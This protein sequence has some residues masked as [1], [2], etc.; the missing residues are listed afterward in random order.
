[1]CRNN[2]YDGRDMVSASRLISKR[3]SKALHFRKRA[4]SE[5]FEASKRW[6]SVKIRFGF[7]G[8]LRITWNKIRDKNHY[9]NSLLICCCLTRSYA[10]AWYRS[11]ESEATSTERRQI[12]PKFESLSTSP[13]HLCQTPDPFI[14]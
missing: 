5:G 11:D 3:M 9:Y 14:I 10:R 12:F 4:K 2:A 6:A 13:E 1:M 7:R 8:F